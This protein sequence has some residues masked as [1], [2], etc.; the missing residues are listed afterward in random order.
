MPEDTQHKPQPAKKEQPKKDGAQQLQP[1]LPLVL[2]V[3]DG[4][5]AAAPSRANAI[6]QAKTPHM[7]AL[8]AEYPTVT[9]HASGE[10]VGL[11][12]AEMGNSEVGHLNIG[13]GKIIY[14]NLPLINKAI[15]DGSFA[16]NEAFLNAISTVK[17]RGSKLHLLGM[18][19]D[20]NIHS[21]QDHLYALLDLCKE[22]E[23]TENV[24]VHAL[25]DGR[26]TAR[27]AALVFL[28]Q[29]ETRMYA[30]GF[31]KIASIAG[32]YFAMDRDNRWDRTEKAY[33]AIRFGESDH[34]SDSALKAIEQAYVR[35]V[36]DEEMPPTVII[37]E[38]GAPIAKVEDGD[39][40]I[41]FNFRADRARQLTKSFVLPG[42]E[43]F[44]RGAQVQELVFVSMTEY[45]KNLPL[46][47]AFQQD[48]VETPI[49]KAVS[50]AGMHQLHVAETEKYAHVTFFFNGGKEDAYENEERA[51]V[52]SPPVASYDE[53]PAMSA[54][55]V[56]DKVIEG[57]ES[58]KYEFIVANFA[59][60]DMVGHTGKLDAAVQAIEAIDEQMGRIAEAVK[61]AN[62][63]MVITADH[64][65]AEEML[66]QQ[67][68]AIIKEH[69]TNPVPF[70]IMHPDMIEQRSMWPKVEDGDLS[71]M[72]PIG[73]LSDAA[74][75]VLKL[76]G[77]DAPPDMTSRSLIR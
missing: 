51:L 34:M 52:P 40:I 33:R 65:N 72:Q 54:S 3:L 5:G 56:A 63:S 26:D 55:G 7:N 21:S 60:A 2:V 44:D 12:Y 17:E 14:Q 37:G 77:V 19:S 20:G 43:K 67:T 62:A 61:K 57:I 70:V 64:G 39:A 24:Y 76:L 46:R 45:E 22:H 13:S 75:T 42:F 71:R 29:L 59:N 49:A 15:A 47:I 58:G 31:G 66:N 74:P 41:F 18:V 73:V 53:T 23:L 10:M 48:T 27:D 68:G 50:D 1:R 32:R 11:P 35:K 36:Y 4:Y 69:S 38:D 8:M 9:L 25:L 6:S 28:S 16:K 30:S